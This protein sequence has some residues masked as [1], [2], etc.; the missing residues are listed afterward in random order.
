MI[1]NIK[2]VGIIFLAVAIVCF[3]TIGCFFA[4]NGDKSSAELQKDKEQMTTADDRAT[5]DIGKTYTDI[6]G[7]SVQ[8][9][10]R[11]NEVR[12]ESYT[13]NKFVKI[14]LNANWIVDVTLNLENYQRIIIDL[15]G[16]SVTRNL[17]AQVSSGNLFNVSYGATLRIMDSVFERNPQAVYDKVEEL[18]DS[19]L[20]YEQFTTDDAQNRD[21]W[22]RDSQEFFRAI[23]ANTGIGYIGGAKNSNAGGG[24]V[25][26]AGKFEFYSGMICNNIAFLGGA[27]YAVHSDSRLIINGGIIACNESVDSSNG[28][29]VASVNT[30][31]SGGM[32][33]GNRAKDRGGAL[34]LS[35]VANVSNCVVYKNC[36]NSM[37]AL[38]L[39]TQERLKLTNVR[40]EGNVSTLHS[41]G[42]AYI[43]G[44]TN[45]TIVDFYNVSFIG[46]KTLTAVTDGI[47][48]SGGGLQVCFLT[49][50]YLQDCIFRDNYSPIGGAG[51]DFSEKGASTKSS[52]LQIGGFLDMSNNLNENGEDADIQIKSN[53]KIRI[54]TALK[55][56]PDN[57]NQKPIKLIFWNK[58]GLFHSFTSSYSTYNHNGLDPSKYFTC[59]FDTHKAVVNSFGELMFEQDNKAIY[60]FMFLQN[61]YRKN[62]DG[63]EKLHGYN[64]SDITTFVLGKISPMTSIDS[65]IE[66]LAPYN[67]AN[68]QLYT[69]TD[70]L[71]YENGNALNGVNSSNGMEFA[72]GTGWYIKCNV[73]ETEETIYLSV[74]G[75][76]T[77]DGKINSADINYLRRV[78]NDITLYTSIVDKP[79]LQLAM[80]INN[81]D[82]LTSSD[83]N[84]LWNVVLGNESIELFM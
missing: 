43:T 35:D 10:T 51:I 32:F 53:G 62:Y 76:L 55:M 4:I 7:T 74:L 66:N 24:V 15:N 50:A 65:F 13:M 78:I 37:G 70:D 81:K 49:Q 75:D 11:W 41:G 18:A 84:I 67:F 9:I 16:H 59:G 64:D 1:K 72:V 40:I 38:Y 45:G 48:D 20:H 34:Y 30:T 12:A 3:M 29:V 44:N 52:K 28:N 36:Q 46:N 57:P 25:V 82:G 19:L 60:D 63:N 39:N 69:N 8:I 22:A 71:V 27:I 58:T 14:V 33:V 77:G 79:Y 54:E 73:G 21:I 80:L 42:G 83:A 17:S 6:Q 2:R 56:N 23:I 47:N 31:I 5:T 26:Y 68:L 61:G